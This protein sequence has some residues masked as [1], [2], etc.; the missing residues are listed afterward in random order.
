MINPE[1]NTDRQVLWT[2]RRM[3]EMTRVEVKR[4]N[5]KKWLLKKSNLGLR[6]WLVDSTKYWLN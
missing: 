6:Y 4:G 3:L 1:V 5:Y 2:W